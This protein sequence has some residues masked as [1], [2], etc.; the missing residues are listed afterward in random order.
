MVFGNEAHGV[1]SQLRKAAD[2]SLMIPIFG[3][4]ESL[5]VATSAAICLY[6]SVRQRAGHREARGT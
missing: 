6:E 5:N 1:S 3:K 4:A 2:I